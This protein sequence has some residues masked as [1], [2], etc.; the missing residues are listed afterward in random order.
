MIPVLQYGI[1]RFL[2]W[3][4]VLSAAG[5]LGLMCDFAIGYSPSLAHI[6]PSVPNPLIE[7]CK[8]SHVGPTIN[9][10]DDGTVVPTLASFLI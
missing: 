2:S 6:N 8:V 5:R 10:E 9:S 3:L 1:L 7:I 4:E